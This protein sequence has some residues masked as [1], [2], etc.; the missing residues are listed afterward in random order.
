[1][2]RDPTHPLRGP[3]HDEEQHLVVVLPA[4]NEADSIPF[5]LDEVAEAADRLRLTGVRTTCLV[6]DD[7]SP[8]GT[9]EV[10]ERAARRLGLELRVVTGERRGLGDAMLRGLAAA[11]ELDPTAVVTL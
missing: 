8:D 10:S 5:V 1:M 2:T 7:N 11:L 6:V 4:Y 3:Q 9:G